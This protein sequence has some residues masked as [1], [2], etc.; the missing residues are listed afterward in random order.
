MT[1]KA[2]RL[3]VPKIFMMTRLVGL[4]YIQGSRFTFTGHR[5]ILAW[6]SRCAGGTWR[7]RSPGMIVQPSPDRESSR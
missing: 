5:E 7:R 2:K 4:S 1:V 6:S 3:P